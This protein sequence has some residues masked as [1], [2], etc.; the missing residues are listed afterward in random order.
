[1]RH[2]LSNNLNPIQAMY[3]QSATLRLRAPEHTDLDFLFHIENDTR[4]WAVSA[5]KIP[6]SR[7]QLQTY[8]ETNS[9]DL[10]ADKQMRLMIDEHDTPIGAI[11]LFD[12][13]PANHRAEVGIVI[14]S[15][16]R[17]KG[18]AREALA[19]VCEYASQVLSL[20]QL[21]AYVYNDNEAAIRLFTSCEFAAVATLPDWAFIEGQYKSVVLYQ[22]IFEK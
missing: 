3:L 5:C 21:Y 9:H 10:Y 18:H 11:D 4:L 7:Y 16:H 6:Y 15:V 13:S 20:H 2:T 1:M 12:F 19:M 14:D 17:H 22:R 8:I